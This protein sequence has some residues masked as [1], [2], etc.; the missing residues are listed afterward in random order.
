EAE[1]QRAPEG[2]ASVRRLGVDHDFLPVEQRRELRGI[3]EGGY[4]GLELGDLHGLAVTGRVVARL[5]LQLALDGVLLR[6]DLLDI[7]GPDL[8][9]EERLV[10]DPLAVRGAAGDE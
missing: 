10:G 3:D 4:L 6:A 8:V 9:D 7:A 1:Q 2:P 5:P